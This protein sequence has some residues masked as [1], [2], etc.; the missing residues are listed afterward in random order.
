MSRRA[1]AHEGARVS[2]PAGETETALGAVL[3]QDTGEDDGAQTDRVA[4]QLWTLVA[5]AGAGGVGLL[6]FLVRAAMGRTKP[7]PPPEES[8]H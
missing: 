7:P 3:A 5:A 2:A 8:P 6:G 4:I 1:V